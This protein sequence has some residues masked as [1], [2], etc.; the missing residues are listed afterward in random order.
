MKSASL[1]CIIN[2]SM[3]FT[4]V[5]WQNE[6]WEGKVSALFD[7]DSVSWQ[8]LLSSHGCLNCRNRCIESTGRQYYDYGTEK[9]WVLVLRDSLLVIH[10]S[11]HYSSSRLESHCLLGLWNKI[12]SCDSLIVSFFGDSKIK[13]STLL[14]K[15]SSR[16]TLFFFPQSW[17]QWLSIPGLVTSQQ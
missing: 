2:C 12:F 16:P 7:C 9:A 5:L 6:N 8:S 3:K 4:H 17:S 10:K 1:S 15:L 13:S 11:R 14:Q